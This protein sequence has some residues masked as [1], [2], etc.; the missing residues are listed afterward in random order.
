MKFGEFSYKTLHE[1]S[2]KYSYVFKD[3]QEDLTESNINFTV[4]E[5]FAAML[6]TVLLSTPL[7]PIL[8]ILFFMLLNDLV[9]S[10]ISGLIFYVL[11]VVGIVVGFYLYPSQQAGNRRKKIDNALHFAAIYMETLAGTGAPPHLLF[12]ILGSFNEFSEI[13]EISRKISRDIEIFG[14]DPTEAISNA[15]KKTPSPNM[16][17]LLWGMKATITSGG[18]LKTYL[19]EKAKAFTSDYKRKLEEFTNVLAVLLE[20]YIT[21]VI[22]GSV[23]ALVL[24]T[25][26][27]LISG[28]LSGI[29]ELQLIIVVI[30]LP[31]MS[32]VFILLIKA[33]SPT[34]V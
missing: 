1:V 14:M 28:G 31:F 22:V 15:A 24:T 2:K 29:A 18:D 8:S 33:S 23:L 34:E 19:N 9:L 25:I 10:I 5:Y 4:Q 13:A 12:R 32:A 20:I 3:L 21:I 6:M 26:M 16:R 7:M 27:S 11:I 30:G 17:E